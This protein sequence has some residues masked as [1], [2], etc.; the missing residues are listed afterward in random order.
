M[1]NFHFHQNIAKQLIW[2]SGLDVST[3]TDTETVT[4]Q[5]QTQHLLYQNNMC[6]HQKMIALRIVATI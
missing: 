2:E 3:E 4:N 5:P 6:D 1:L